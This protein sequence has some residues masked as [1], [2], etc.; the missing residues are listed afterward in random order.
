MFPRRTRGNTHCLLAVVTV[1]LIPFA[2]SLGGCAVGPDYVRPETETP[3]PDAWNTEIR[4]ELSKP[5]SETKEWWTAF[6]D[7]ML[8]HLIARADTMNRDLRVAIAR[9]EEARALRGIDK[10]DFWPQVSAA[11]SFTRQQISNNGQG[12]FLGADGDIPANNMWFAGFDAAWELDVFGGI[13]RRVEAS[14][15]ELQASV[16][17]YRDVMVTLYAEVASSYIQVRTTQTRL[18]FA[19]DNVEA[20][21]GSLDITRTRFE[22]G[23]TSAL[24]V[25]Q[26][27]ANLSGTLSTIPQ[28]DARLVAALN[29]LAVL[30]GESPG[31]LDEQ[32]GPP[33]AIPIPTSEVTRGMPAEL[34]RRRPDI[35][36]AE[37]QLAAQTAR[38]GVATS[39]LYPKFGLP[40]MLGWQ[41]KD[42]DNLFNA[43]SLTWSFMPTI[44][45]NIFNAGKVKNNIKA[46]EART[47]SALLFY[48]QTILLALEEVENALTNY[49]QEQLRR[50]HLRDAV[51][52]AGRSVELVQTQ[53]LSG[54]TNFQ[55]L[56]DSQRTLFTRE[57]DLAS[58]EGLV[59]QNLIALNKALGGGWSLEDEYP[60]FT[61]RNP[62]EN[63]HQDPTEETNSATEPATKDPA[64]DGAAGSNETTG[65][66]R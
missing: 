49:Q 30:L 23:L 29:R 8:T 61:R 33:L 66:E 13:R 18:S 17:D 42:S 48:E 15:A 25:A 51:D 41:S 14:T 4:A 24:D 20:Q 57:D 5:Q 16:E 60:E 50:K 27:E 2:L 7:T 1:C 46:E 54:L 39:D 63:P 43:S 10:A 64:A 35:R 52:A 32:L 53:Y 38:I 21:R 26:A 36:R 37:R 11:G 19:H 45:W 9:I 3:V 59:V 40:G 58:S 47:E 28:L 44:K 62:G 55:N 12:A 56:L 65:G 34:L 31:A 22:T 6:E